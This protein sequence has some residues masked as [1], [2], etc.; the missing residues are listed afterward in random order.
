MALL[1]ADVNVYIPLC[2]ESY[3]NHEFTL[4]KGGGM[5]DEE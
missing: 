1:T 5:S 4:F 3:T 2:W